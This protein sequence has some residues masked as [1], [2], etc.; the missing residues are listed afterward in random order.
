MCVCFVGYLFV[1][2]EVVGGVGGDWVVCCVVV[3][4][5]FWCWFVSDCWGYVGLLGCGVFGGFW[6]VCVGWVS[7]VVVLVC[8]IGVGFCVGGLGGWYGGI[9]CVD[10]DVVDVGCECV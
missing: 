5:L 10:E 4:G 2:G 9:L 7:C 3:V 1:V 6:G 8:F